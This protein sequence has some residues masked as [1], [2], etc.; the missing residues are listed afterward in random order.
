MSNSQTNPTNTT[1]TKHK[2]SIITTKGRYEALAWCTLIRLR[3]RDGVAG[4]CHVAV[5]LF[6]HYDVEVP[7][8]PKRQKCVIIGVN[9]A[10]VL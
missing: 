9:I 5:E 3:D 10:T 6:D 7:G 8:N 2:V 1:S 4:L